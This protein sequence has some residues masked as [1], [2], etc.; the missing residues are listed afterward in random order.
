MNTVDVLAL[1]LGGGAGSRL[2]P[3]TKERAKPAVPI[4]GMYR[5]VDIPISNCLNS[6]L[7]QIYILTQ[8][9]SVSLH[10]H[11]TRTYK[12]DAFS[13]GWVQI[14]AAEQTPRS[15]DWYQGTAD[16]LRKQLPELHAID[17]NDFLILAG[18]HLYRMDY[19]AFIRAHREA[20]ADITVSVLPV[21]REE[22]SR[23]GIVET[24]TRGRIVNFHEKPSDPKVLNALAT[25][26]DPQRPF[27]GSM[28]IYL[29]RSKALYDLLEKHAGSDFGKDIL[30]DSIEKYQVLAYPFDDYWE[31]IGT[32]RSFYAANLVLA[33]ANPPFSFYDPERPIYT[34]PRFLPPTQLIDS[35]VDRVLLCDGCKVF[36]SHIEE[37][38]VGIRSLI[39]PDVRMSRT[40]MMGGDYY[41]TEVD[42]V[43]NAERNT[44]NIGIGRGSTIEG[45][46]LDK[47]ARIG[48]DVVI[49]YIPDRDNMETDQY[50]IRDGITI[51]MKDGMIPAGTVI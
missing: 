30:P 4:G 1:I 39:G 38:I 36:N 5:L 42:K 16:A 10:R 13:P 15:S 51:V 21:S 18:D 26:P 22:A 20:R 37:S 6:G 2:H 32:I 46:I 23:F 12:F 9:N 50:V 14:L 45:A 24:D 35:T 11:I 31:D 19:A 40:V 49:R 34:H 25:Y 41:E 47:G 28:G 17:P 33:S 43:H 7:D 48:E 8:F 3:L 29:F 44:P 27:L